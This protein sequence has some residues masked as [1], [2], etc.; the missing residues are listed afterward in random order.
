VNGRTYN[1]SVKRIPTGDLRTRLEDV[2]KL[3]GHD[4]NDRIVL[5]VALVANSN[6]D[7]CRSPVTNEALGTGI[8]DRLTAYSLGT[9]AVNL[10]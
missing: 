6:S 2:G 5:P 4:T 8:E 9:G 7:D 3:K 10:L 1:A